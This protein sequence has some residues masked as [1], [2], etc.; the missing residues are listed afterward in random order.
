VGSLQ[1][2]YRFDQ[3]I[4]PSMRA[5]YP[6]AS[7]VPIV[8]HTESIVVRAALQTHS[9]NRGPSHSGHEHPKQ[10]FDTQAFCDQREGFPALTC[11]NHECPG[12]LPHREYPVLERALSQARINKQL[13][14]YLDAVRYRR[15][16]QAGEARRVGSIVPFPAI[17]STTPFG[18]QLPRKLALNF[19]T[20][21]ELIY[22]AFPVF[23]LASRR[24][25]LGERTVKV[26]L[27]V[28]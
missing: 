24:S 20:M 18:S 11:Q 7:L 5:I 15:R 17:E 9:Y 21:Y 23:H 26:P 25:S 3:I 4:C 14:Q 2:S 16:S 13:K 12:T 22:L 27:F 28:I 19:P 10:F 6:H 8:N 1:K